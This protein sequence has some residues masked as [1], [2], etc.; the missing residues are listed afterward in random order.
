MLARMAPVAATTQQTMARVVVS[1]TSFEVFSITSENA[2]IS[3]RYCRHSRFKL[4]S[5]RVAAFPPLCFG[6]V[7]SNHGEIL[8]RSSFVDMKQSPFY[9]SSCSSCQF[10]KSSHSESSKTS[11]SLTSCSSS[12]ISSETARIEP[13][14]PHRPTKISSDANGEKIGEDIIADGVFQRGK[15]VPK[16]AGCCGVGVIICGVWF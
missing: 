1:C 8:L 2:F 13:A 6:R 15:R 4:V 12:A 11:H 7:S 3:S 14:S 5:V 16:S 9:S 10:L